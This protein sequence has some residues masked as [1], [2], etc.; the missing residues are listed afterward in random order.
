MNRWFLNQ[1]I[2]ESTLQLLIFQFHHIY[3]RNLIQMNFNII[4]YRIVSAQLI[5]VLGD[6]RLEI[7]PFLKPSLVKLASEIIAFT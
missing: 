3:L 2:F 5:T 4:K 6:I 1:S 7:S